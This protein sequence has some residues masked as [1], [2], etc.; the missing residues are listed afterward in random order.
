MVIIIKNHNFS[1]VLIEKTI[2]FLVKRYKNVLIVLI[3]IIFNRLYIYI[4]IFVTQICRSETVLLK[5]LLNIY[6]T[7][8]IKKKKKHRYRSYFLMGCSSAL[9]A[10]LLIL[11]F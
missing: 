6:Y 1:A 7:Q 3:L 11:F 5:I 9:C 2:K 10:F 4:Y 8:Q